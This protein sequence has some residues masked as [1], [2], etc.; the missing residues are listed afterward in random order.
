MLYSRTRGSGLIDFSGPNKFCQPVN[1]DKYTLGCHLFSKFI[2]F[3]YV[4]QHFV[5][6]HLKKVYERFELK[7]TADQTN[8]DLNLKFHVTT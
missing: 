2:I 1:E 3:K 6:I 7:E 8:A 4:S 5:S